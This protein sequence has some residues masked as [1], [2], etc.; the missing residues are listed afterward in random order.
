MDNFNLM[1]ERLATD[2]FKQEDFVI[3]NLDLMYKR[4]RGGNTQQAR[5]IKDKRETLER[6]VKYSYQGA[7]VL[8]IGDTE[9]AAAL[10]NPNTV[11]QDY[12]DKIISINFDYGYS[13]GTVFDW[14]NTGTKWLIYLQDLTELAYFK[15]DIRKCNYE[16][17]WEDKDDEGKTHKYTTYVALTGPS[18]KKIDS[19]I[20]E[21]I[22][23]DSPN[24][25]LHFYMPNNEYTSKY[26]DRYSK[27]YLSG[28][29][30]CWRIEAIDKI[31]MPGILE[32]YAH[33]YYANEHEDN[34]E[35]GLVGDLIVEPI[36]PNSPVDETNEYIKGET[37][38]KPKRAYTYEYLGA[39]AGIWNWDKKLPIKEILP[40][41]GNSNDKKIITIKWDTTYSGQFTLSF[42]K[43][44]K[45]IVVE[46]LF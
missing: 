15:G 39:A 37:F 22:S 43:V 11:K 25:S 4:I 32:V 1:R 33:E 18:E 16:I 24:Y 10:I 35:E 26:F 41:E 40:E 29:S 23:I 28:L 7:Q 27:F 2:N 21:D 17:K 12:D 44:E 3:S 8:A 38:I 5:M 34:I 36:D 6:V 9:P 46:S 19:S 45:T 30:T 14:L 20:K 31:S 13:V 42:G